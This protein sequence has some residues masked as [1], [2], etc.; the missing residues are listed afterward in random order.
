PPAPP[1]SAIASAGPASSLRSGPCPRGRVSSSGCLLL[2][3]VELLRVE[4]RLEPRDQLLL[5]ELPARF[6]T[7]EFLVVQQHVGRAKPL[8]DDGPDRLGQTLPGVLA[9]C[10]PLVEGG[11]GRKP[12]LERPRRLALDRDRSRGREERRLKLGPSLAD[13]IDD[14]GPK[15]CNPLEIQQLLHDRGG[16][17]SRPCFR[18]SAWPLVGLGGRPIGLRGRNRVGRRGSGALRPTRK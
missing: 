7:A 18:R 1:S 6:G 11:A 8:A 15:L 2:G 13:P 14:G 3:I 9:L 5:A 10:L 16:R 17:R 12:D 4:L